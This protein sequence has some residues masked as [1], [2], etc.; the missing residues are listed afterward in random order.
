MKPIFKKSNGPFVNGTQE[1]IALMETNTFV[2]QVGSDVYMYN[3]LIVFQKDHAEKL[4][5]DVLNGLQL[6]A[7]E[8]S[9]KERRAALKSL[10]SVRIIPF[11]VQ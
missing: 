1:N 7:K 3:N 8:G 5:F 6:M 11:K 10:Y 4:Y 9:P 2:I